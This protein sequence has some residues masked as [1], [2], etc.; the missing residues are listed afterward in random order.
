MGVL[1]IHIQDG[2]QPASFSRATKRDLSSREDASDTDST[3][4]PATSLCCSC[5]EP[6]WNITLTKRAVTALQRGCVC[7]ALKHIFKNSFSETWN[8][9]Y[10]CLKTE[11]YNKIKFTCNT[12][13][14]NHSLSVLSSFPYGFCFAEAIQC[15][16][17]IFVFWFV[18]ITLG[19]KHCPIKKN[20][21]FINIISVAK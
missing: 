9:T 8:R 13:S 15:C 11:N 10:S 16:I 12:L 1:V 14:N 21:L 4:C 3:P 19:Y 7:H 20:T 6:H 18:H 17:F 2:T 5:I